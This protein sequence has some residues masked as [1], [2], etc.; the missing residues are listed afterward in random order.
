MHPLCFVILT[1][2]FGVENHD[3]LCD[4]EYSMGGS[5]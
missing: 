2:A 1:E 4:L 5:P 3:A